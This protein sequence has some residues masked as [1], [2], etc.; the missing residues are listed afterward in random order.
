MNNRGELSAFK[1]WL[2]VLASL[3]DE[4][5]L[6]VLIFLALRYF[7]VKITWPIILTAGLAV[8]IFFVIMHKAVV[9]A[10]RRRKTTGAEG[11]I[12]LTGKVTQV[13]KPQGVIKIK[14]EY[15]QAKSI[16]GDI[17]IDE[18]VEVVEIHGLMLEVKR[19][20]L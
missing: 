5:V 9:P 18:D 10:I 2:I 3:L 16:N 14:D 11:M 1:A 19:K 8:V 17:G 15:W 13:L 12:G 4:A 6:L 7:H 20:T